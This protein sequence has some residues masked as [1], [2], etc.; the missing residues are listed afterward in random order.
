MLTSF[1]L[2]LPDMADKLRHKGRH[3][4]DTPFGVS[5]PNLLLGKSS[6][7]N[8]HHYWH[9]DSVKNV[10]DGLQA[11]KS[12]EIAYRSD[13][14]KPV[15]GRNA[16]NTPFFSSNAPSNV[17]TAR[18]SGNITQ[19][20]TASDGDMENWRKFV[21]NQRAEGYNAIRNSQPMPQPIAP[22]MQ[23]IMADPNKAMQNQLDLLLTAIEERVFGGIVDNN[24]FKELNEYAR[25]LE[26]VISSYDDAQ[27]ITDLINRFG[28]LEI[29]VRGIASRRGTLG[30][31]TKEANYAESTLALIQRIIQF[32]QANVS[33]VGRN[34][35][36]RQLLQRGTHDILTKV[37]N[38]QRVPIKGVLTQAEV[39]QLV[40]S[41][42][43]SREYLRELPVGELL[44][45]AR[46]VDFRLRKQPADYKP[47]DLTKALRKGISSALFNIYDIDMNLV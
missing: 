18:G 38:P 30:T 32:L 12:S 43:W 21:V 26:Q 4:I 23:G 19:S 40:S 47:A 24:G 17:V 34:E 35:L 2:T 6:A 28:N 16:T 10:Y 42:E 15:A 22:K 39:Q 45:I 14:F 1:S 7:D 13:R 5:H 25:G 9:K 37:G 44:Q 41:G 8:T 46:N 3:F 11:N 29:T 27:H 36:T 31:T 20:S 33:G